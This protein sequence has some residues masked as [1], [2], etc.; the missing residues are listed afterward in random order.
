MIYIADLIGVPYKDRGRDASGYDCYGLAIEVEKRMGKKLDDVYYTDH[1]LKL[2]QENIPL[3]NIRERTDSFIET[4]DLIEIKLKNELHIG[5]ALDSVRFIHAT[6]NQGV[7]I[8]PIKAY[9]VINVY[10]VLADGHN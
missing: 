4:G 1:S 8:S 2:S 7:R 10:E 5:V 9:P 3:L 6:L